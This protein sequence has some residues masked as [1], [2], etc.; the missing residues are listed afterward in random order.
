METIACFFVGVAVG[1]GI[2]A[3]LAVLLF[4]RW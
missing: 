1:F 3:I 2:G 4:E